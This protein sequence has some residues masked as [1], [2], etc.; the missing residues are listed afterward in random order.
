MAWQAS[1]APRLTAVCISRQG[2]LARGWAM[3]APTAEPASVRRTEWNRHRNGCMLF[4]SW[5]LPMPARG[6]WAE[7]G[8]GLSAAATWRHAAAACML[9]AFSRYPSE[10]A[11]AAE[12]ADEPTATRLPARFETP[13]T[14]RALG[15]AAQRRRSRTLV[16]KTNSSGEPRRRRIHLYTL[17]P[18]VFLVP[19]AGA[20][21]SSQAHWLV[22]RVF[23]PES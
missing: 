20:E 11:A 13:V 18:A 7:G 9:Q 16:D 21:A 5:P 4:I 1:C 3:G 14:A 10:S 19:L 12:L 15:T 17:F 23:G 6:A 22:T 8:W 2:A